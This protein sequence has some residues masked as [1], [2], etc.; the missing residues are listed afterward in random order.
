MEKLRRFLIIIGPGMLTAATGVGAGD[1]ATGSFAGSLLGTAIL[2]AVIVGALLKYTVTEGI[3]RWQLATGTTLLEGL[4]IHFGR[5]AAWLFLPYLFLF[6]YFIGTAMM[7]ACGVTLHAM[8]PLFD[9][10]ADGKIFFG[11]LSSI[12]GLAL[13]YKGGYQLFE[14]TMQVCIGIMFFTVIITTALL[15]PGTEIILRGIFIPTIPDFHGDG[16]IWTVALIGGVGGTVTVLS[17]GYW[18]REEGRT[19]GNDIPICRIDLVAG[20]VMTALFGLAMV[21][22][23]ST[24]TIQGGGAT[25]LVNLSEQLGTELGPAGKWLFLI[26]AFGTVF[27]SLLGVWQSIPY[28]FTDT[29]LLASQPR[30]HTAARSTSFKI[31]LDTPLYRRYMIV[32]AC[33]PMLGLFT[34]FH[35]VQKFYAVAGAYFFPFLAIALLL[36]NCQARWVGEQYRYGPL[37]IIGLIATIALFIWAATHN[38]ST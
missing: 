14:K 15:W 32:I 3:A 29:W 30:S 16:L 20:Y 34:S 7:S 4:T 22:I 10:A 19:G 35:Q 17:Y 21:I 12:V 5:G 31:G 13:V 1:L 8:I 24:I 28:I 6:T 11:I 36:L 33:V 18:I 2:W 26:G 25:L 27:S 38:I 9:D 23:G 37:A